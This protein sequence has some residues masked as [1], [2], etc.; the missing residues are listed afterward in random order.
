VA[1]NVTLHAF[2]AV[3][4]LPLG[5]SR[6]AIDRYL[7][8]AGLTEAQLLHAAAAVVRT[9]RQTDTVPLHKPWRI[10][11]EQRQQLTQRLVQS[12]QLCTN[13]MKL[14]GQMESVYSKC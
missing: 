4:P 5:A 7:L 1:G 14:W 9:D 2:A 10:L 8:T 11:F 6:A 13:I 3:A 12:F